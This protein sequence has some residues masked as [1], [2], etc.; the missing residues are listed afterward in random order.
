MVS[1]ADDDMIYQKL[2]RMRLVDMLKEFVKSLAR[3]RREPLDD[4]LIE[5]ELFSDDK[6]DPHSIIC[7]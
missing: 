1:K 5:E 2:L 6:I 7:R 4:H 3:R